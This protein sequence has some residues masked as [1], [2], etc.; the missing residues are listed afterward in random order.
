MHEVHEDLADAILVR[1]DA[2]Q[3]G[4]D[5]DVQRDA[6]AL[7]EQPQPLGR[8]GGEPAQVDILG[9]RERCAG[10]DPRQVEQ[11]VDHLHE[12]AHLD[13]DL[14]DPVAHLRRHVGGLGL[15]GERLREQAHGRQR[16]PKLVARRCR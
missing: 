9:H 8:A 16:R 1:P 14:A 5:L 13:L 2:W 10:L 12:M 11:L 6:L 3:I 4:L 7:R 15:P